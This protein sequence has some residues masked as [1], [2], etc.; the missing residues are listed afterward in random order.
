MFASVCLGFFILSILIFVFYNCSDL[1]RKIGF[2]V[3]AILNLCL[4]YTLCVGVDGFVLKGIITAPVFE[5]DNLARFFAFIVAII[6]LASS[7]H[8]LWY[9]KTFKFNNAVFVS[10]FSGFELSMIMLL[11]SSNV[12][13]FIIL[14]EVM[15]LL[16]ALMLKFNDSQNSNKIVM[17]YLG[18]AQLGAFCLIIAL[19]WLNFLGGEDIR[20][21]SNINTP[22]AVCI[23]ILILIGFGSKAGMIGFHVWSPLAYTLAPSN[24]SSMMSAAMSKVAIFGLIKFTLLLD[25]NFYFALAVMILGAFGALYGVI[26]AL[27]QNSYKRLVAYS[28]VEN[29]GII[30][31]AFGLGLFG[32]ATKNSLLTTLGLVAALFHCLNHALFK[33]L[34]FLACGNIYATT[35]KKL[36]DELGGLNKYLKAT[37]ICVMIAC[38]AIAALP[39]L[40]GFFSEWLIYKGLLNKLDFVSA[41]LVFAICLISL[42]LMGVI[43][44]LAFIKFYGL[45]FSGIARVDMTIGEQPGVLA[46]LALIILAI[47]CVLV[48]IFANDIS[49]CISTTLSTH[50][51]ASLVNTELIN[52]PLVWVFLLALIAL[53]FILAKLFTN[54]NL[55]FTKPWACGFKYDN[56]MQASSSSLIADIRKLVKFIVN[57][58]MSFKPDGYFG[59]LEYKVST[60]DRFYTHIYEP[61]IKFFEVFG[62]KIGIVQNGKAGFYIAYILLYLFFMLS[63]VFYFLGG[64]L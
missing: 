63:G 51:N 6:A 21:W 19:L 43:C 38:I 20:A 44:V 24:V 40:N 35:R 55:R 58:K 23:A 49:A 31:L 3:L 50:A 4:I 47:L 26:F 28:S 52:L 56:S 53:P 45:L 54:P 27:V 17:L 11:A 39:P 1:A 13:I 7:L 37:G 60:S 29:I 10:L 12:F 36:F 25:L 41:R 34:L 2:S 9:N 62:D 30:L 42:A 61:I 46:N 15:T 59:A 18:I 33:S 22:Y 5:M 48:S 57:E 14:W 32:L 64:A 8:S 16:S